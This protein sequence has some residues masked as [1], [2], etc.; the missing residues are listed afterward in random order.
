MEKNAEKANWL[1]SDFLTENPEV[2][3]SNLGPNKMIGYMFKGMG[4]EAAFQVRK[5]QQQQIE[6]KKVRTIILPKIVQA[7]STSFSFQKRQEEEARIEK[8]WFTL[9]TQLTRQIYFKDKELQE[10]QRSS[11][12]VSLLK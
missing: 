4:P 10:Q 12:T 2:A 11:I 1:T 5:F 9:K 6:E 7:I 3:M 8:E